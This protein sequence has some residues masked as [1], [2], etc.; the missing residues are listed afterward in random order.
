MAVLNIYQTTIGKKIVMAVTGIILVLFVIVHMWGNL[1]FFEGPARTNAYGVFLREFG[2]PFLTHELALWIA[3]V[4]LLASVVLHVVAAYQLS[5]L[6]LA[7]RP[8]GYA[9]RKNLQSGYAVRTM[10]WGGVLLA[11]FIVF[12]ILHFTTGTLLPGFREGQIYQNMVIGLRSPL[13]ALFY[14]VSMLALGLHLVHGVWST[15][16]TLGVNNSKRTRL[17]GSVAYVVAV[18]V[19]AGFIAVP[20]AVVTGLAR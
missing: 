9:T 17:L 8:I 5:R 2:A 14:I 18:V 20:V 13:V 6:D 19:T 1:H 11:I 4:V 3:R 12:H 7:S 10:R 16:Q 15:F